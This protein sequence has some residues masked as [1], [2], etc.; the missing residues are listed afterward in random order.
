MRIFIFTCCAACIIAL[1]GLGLLHYEANTS[2]TLVDRTWNDSRTCYIDVY[3]RNYDAFGAIGRAVALLS[4]SFTYRV[5]T[6]GGRLLKSTDWQLDQCP[7]LDA[8][9]VWAGQHVL[10]PTIH[11]YQNWRVPDCK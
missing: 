3:G 10:Y 4:S 1:L 2:A 8:A 6:S 9:P 11:G 7:I 5:F